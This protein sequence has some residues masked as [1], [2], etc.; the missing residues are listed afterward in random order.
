MYSYC[1]KFSPKDL[2]CPCNVQLT[3]KQEAYKS[4]FTRLQPL[5]FHQLL[6]EGN[7]VHVRLWFGNELLLRSNIK[8]WMKMQAVATVQ[9][10]TLLLVCYIFTCQ[11]TYGTCKGTNKQFCLNLIHS[12]KIS[13]CSKC[14][15]TKVFLMK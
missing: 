10:T 11:H 2:S 4:D 13:S 1:V 15:N 3:G 6:K 9:N 8:S 7:K 12:L 5:Y 14:F